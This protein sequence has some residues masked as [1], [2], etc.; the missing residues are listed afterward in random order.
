M[1][2]LK[3]GYFGQSHIQ[4][5]DLAMTVEEAIQQANPTLSSQ[6]VRSICGKMLFTQSRSEKKIGVLSGGERSRVVLGKLLA[7]SSHLLLLDEP[8]N[9]LDIESMEAF[10][11]ALEEFEGAV[12][13][14]TH[15]ELLL[16]RLATE[17]I[18]F[19][20]TGQSHFVGT[21]DEFLDK[22]GWGDEVKLQS[23][24]ENSYKDVKRLK[25]E[26]VNER[27]KKLKPHQSRL[28]EVEA[29]IMKLEKELECS[30]AAL[31]K[32]SMEQKGELIALHSKAIKEAASQIETLFIELE[33]SH[34]LAEAIKSEYQTKF[35]ALDRE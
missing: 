1:Q 11:D 32:A 12:C 15:S 6:Q 22:G 33:Q 35:D 5:L 10:M 7:T 19:K 34:S 23:K 30:N 13:I 25:A 18:V 2:G 24:P 21:Y 17:L 8:T 28:Q 4:R 9:H 14:V 26:L 3:V 20:E 29:H 31:L 27:A 16:E